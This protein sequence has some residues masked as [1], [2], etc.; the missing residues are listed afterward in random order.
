[1]EVRGTSDEYPFGG[2][3]GGRVKLLLK[4]LL[5]INGSITAECE[6]GGSTGGGGFGARDRN[7]H[8]RGERVVY[9]DVVRCWILWPLGLIAQ[10]TVDV[11]QLIAYR[12]CRCGESPDLKPP[13]TAEQ[14]N[15]NALVV[16]CSSRVLAAV[17]SSLVCGS[18]G[19]IRVSRGEDCRVWESMINIWLHCFVVT[20]SV[21]LGDRVGVGLKLKMDCEHPVAKKNEGVPNTVE[22]TN[23]TLPKQSSVP[24][25]VAMVGFVLETL[26]L[27]TEDSCTEVQ[28]H[29]EYFPEFCNNCHSLG[30]SVGRCN[31]MNRRAPQVAKPSENGQGETKQ[32]TKKHKPPSSVPHKNSVPPMVDSGVADSECETDHAD[33]DNTKGKGVQTVSSDKSVVHSDTVLN[34]TFDDLDDELPITKAGFTGPPDMQVQIEMGTHPRSVDMDTTMV[35]TSQPRLAARNLDLVASDHSVSETTDPSVWT[36]VKRKLGRP[37]K[38][39]QA[40]MRRDQPPAVPIKPATRATTSRN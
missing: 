16:G 17:G 18:A 12:G 8:R 6:D 21:L 33:K 35:L 5:Y 10:V 22:F 31:M 4:D 38:L 13:L 28:L 2:N 20:V 36:T 24:S 34:D 14:L 1:M 9:F 40:V 23:G 39:E 15:W 25:Y 26:L 19:F 32:A 30:H 27:E 37:T 7:R 3:G 11:D 29:F